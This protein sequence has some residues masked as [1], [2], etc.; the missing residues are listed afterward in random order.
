MDEIGALVLSD[1][2]EAIRLRD[3]EVGHLGR[4][5]RI[6]DRPL[7]LGRSAFPQID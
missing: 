1:Q 7:D 6:G 3:A 4:M 5:H 2:L